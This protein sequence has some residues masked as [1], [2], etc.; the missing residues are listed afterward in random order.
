MA[1]YQ[2]VARSPSPGPA[3]SDTLNSPYDPYDENMSLA[4]RSGQLNNSETTF[5]P[6]KDL[7]NHENISMVSAQAWRL[8]L[9]SS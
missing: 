5:N 8:F 2:T 3:R 7:Y 4:R 6:Y 9:S 1:Q